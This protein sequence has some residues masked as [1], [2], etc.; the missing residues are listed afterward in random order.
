[1]YTMQEGGN[2]NSPGQRNWLEIDKRI[3]DVLGSGATHSAL[4]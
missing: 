3:V 2:L 4:H 1:M